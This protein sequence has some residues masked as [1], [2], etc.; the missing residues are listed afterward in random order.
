MKLVFPGGE[1]PQVLLGPGINRIGSDPHANIVIDRPGVLPQHCELHV[2]AHGVTLHVPPGTSVT[3][4]GRAV[5]GLIALRPDDSVAFDRVL[6]RLSSIET[7]S[8]LPRG[9]GPF[10]TPA[11][12]D[13]GATAVRPVLPKFVLRGVSG[14]GFGRSYPLVGPTVVG[15]APE[16]VLRLDES[17]LSRQHARLVP[18]AEGMQVE[19]L[20]ST[21]GTFINGK[22]IQRGFASPGDEIGFDTLRFRLTS[23]SQQEPA[24][25]IAPT[26][27]KRRGL[28]P[29]LWVSIAA[30]GL[31]AIWMVAL[32]R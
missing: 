28:S 19:D 23:P 8:P 20:G 27:A 16:C 2:N 31:V 1:H 10:P 18:T 14:Q 15:R 22:R 7:A 30:A 6:A 32:L 13:P 9:A 12:D 11:N 29:W 26:V 3:V 21:N 24:A 4:N 25:P 17:G 5:D